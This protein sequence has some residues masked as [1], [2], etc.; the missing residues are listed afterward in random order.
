VALLGG[1]AAAALVA[2]ARP[3][4][5]VA[6]AQSHTAFVIGACAIAAAGLVLATGVMLALRR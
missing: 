5:V 2:L 6:Y 4:A 3:H 1:I